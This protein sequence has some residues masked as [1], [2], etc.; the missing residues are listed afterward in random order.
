M[1]Q[2]TAGFYLGEFISISMASWRKAF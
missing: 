1:M 2:T